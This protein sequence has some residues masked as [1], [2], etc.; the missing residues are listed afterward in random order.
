MF[1]QNTEVHHH[2]D[3]C[4]L[5][6]FGSFLM[7]NFFLHPYRWNFQ[8]NRLIDNFLHVFWAAEDIYDVDLLG[9]LQQ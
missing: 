4:F 2:K 3:A 9:N 1:L 6:F 5:R 8:R 7:D